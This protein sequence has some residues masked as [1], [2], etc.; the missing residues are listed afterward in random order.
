MAANQKEHTHAKQGIKC[1]HNS[2][3]NTLT[4]IKKKMHTCMEFR[5]FLKLAKITVGVQAGFAVTFEHFKDFF[6]NLDF[7]NKK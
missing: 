3:T 5:N 4:Q 1:Q 2:N 6:L 7:L